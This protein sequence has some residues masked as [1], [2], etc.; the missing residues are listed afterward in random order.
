MPEVSLGEA[1][2]TDLQVRS[3]VKFGD[4]DGT[5]PVLSLGAM[6]VKG[7]KGKTK[8][9]PAGIEVVTQGESRAA[10]PLPSALSLITQSTN[11]P[12][13]HWISEADLKRP[14]KRSE[15]ALEPGISADIVIVPITSTSSDRHRSTRPSSRS[16]RVAET[17]SI[18]RSEARSK[19]TWPRCSGTEGGAELYLFCYRSDRTWERPFEPRLY[20]QLPRAVTGVMHSQRSEQATRADAEEVG[21]KQADTTHCTAQR[22][23]GKH[24]GSR[25]SGRYAA[26]ADCLLRFG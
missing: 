11:I 5:I 4:G 18:T 13:N 26:S 16:L 21:P 22:H 20:T 17:S 24:Y 10:L 19:S 8:W 1:A 6:C 7:W 14:F 3:G 15:S 25:T 12:R 9:N 23:V 2:E